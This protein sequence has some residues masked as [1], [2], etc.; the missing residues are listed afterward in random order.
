MEAQGEK[1]EERE[2]E[3]AS[4]GGGWRDRL[5]SACWLSKENALVK[6]NL[7]SCNPFELLLIGWESMRVKGKGW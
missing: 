4:G 6:W 1:R 3:V 7:I 5:M 2:G